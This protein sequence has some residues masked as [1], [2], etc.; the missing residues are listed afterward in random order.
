M[1]F[2]R[3]WSNKTEIALSRFITWLA[4]APSK[5]Y[6]WKSRY[7]KVNEHNAWIPRDF[8]V[9]DWEKQVIVDFYAEHTTDGYRRVAFMML[10]ANLVAVSPSTVYRVLTNAGVL[11]SW[12]RKPTGN[13]HL[14]L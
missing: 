11:G 13:R 14:C 4:I 1:D 5:Y 12:N 3:C 2:V 8:W 6:D 9:E 10:D 7:G